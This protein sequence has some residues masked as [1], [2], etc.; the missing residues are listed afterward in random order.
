MTAIKNRIL[1]IDDEPPIRR[2]LRTGLATQGFEIV[3][4]S[5]GRTAL[6]ALK[7]EEPDLIILDLG[8]PDISGPLSRS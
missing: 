6:E 5:N 4:A 1:V 3:D 2:L 8:L 7:G